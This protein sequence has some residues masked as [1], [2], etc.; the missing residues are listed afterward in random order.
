MG[1]LGVQPAVAIPQDKAE[2]S[3]D[4]GNGATKGANTVDD[5]GS[6]TAERAETPG[7]DR[8]ADSIN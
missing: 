2:A 6:D 3:A 5:A 4:T 7:P 1:N 8:P